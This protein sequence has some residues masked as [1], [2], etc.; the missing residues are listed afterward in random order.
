MKI[1]HISVA[2]IHPFVENQ[3]FVESLNIQPQKLPAKKVH[4]LL[5]RVKNSRRVQETLGC[6]RAE[7][8]GDM[9]AIVLAD[10][11]GM[12]HKLAL[13]GNKVQFTNTWEDFMYQDE[14]NSTEAC[15]Y[16]VGDDIDTASS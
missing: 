9:D 2:Y 4:A 11:Q 3:N 15:I 13:H 6:L 14:V 12:E 8:N 10:V 1:M 7:T 16:S 5:N